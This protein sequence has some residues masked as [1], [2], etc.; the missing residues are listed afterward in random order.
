MEK[1]IKRAASPY[2]ITP[3]PTEKSNDAA[4]TPEVAPVNPQAAQNVPQQSQTSA[5][6]QNTN[7]IKTN[8]LRQSVRDFQTNLISFYVIV[9]NSNNTD[10]NNLLN[11][12]ILSTPDKKFSDGMFGKNTYD[13]AT[14]SGEV[15]ISVVKFAQKY[16]IKISE[17]NDYSSMISLVESSYIDAINSINE[18]INNKD[19]ERIIRLLEQ[20]SAYINKFKVFYGAI[21]DKSDDII[22]ASKDLE[23]NEDATHTDRTKNTKYNSWNA[24]VAR[25]DRLGEKLT[26]DG[27]Q[28]FVP[29][30]ALSSDKSNF[31]SWV[32]HTFYNDDEDPSDDKIK[33][34]LT[35]IKNQTSKNA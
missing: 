25:Y 11:V 31:G 22:K 3:P 21:K 14:N 2:D 28:V 5:I 12:D 24:P 29:Y 30:S 20:T 26:I 18:N 4:T 23:D 8:K 6:K 35:Q 34:I 27:K 19:Q 32:K 13:Y 7:P 1:Q 33:D 9:N 10:F 17:K 15:I 16:N